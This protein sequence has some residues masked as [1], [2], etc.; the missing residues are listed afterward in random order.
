MLFFIYILDI[1]DS[2]LCSVTLLATSWN[3]MDVSTYSQTCL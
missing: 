1:D 3:T 2:F